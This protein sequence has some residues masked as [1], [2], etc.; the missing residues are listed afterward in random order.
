MPV[1]FG[2]RISQLHVKHF[3][4]Q[5]IALSQILS[6]L[7]PNFNLIIYRITKSLSNY[8]VTIAVL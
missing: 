2:S 4:I 1:T 6:R 3:V 5:W 8:K 7:F